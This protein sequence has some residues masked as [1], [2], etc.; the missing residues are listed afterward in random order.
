[1]QRVHKLALILTTTGALVSGALAQ[2]VFQPG[3]P[4]FAAIDADG[5]GS[6]SSTEYEQFH[7]QRMTQRAAQGYGMRRGGNAPAFA[8][9]DRDGDGTV[10]ES[11]LYQLR[12]DRQAARR[13][14]APCPRGM[15]PAF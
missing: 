4:S 10:T 15:P 12:A 6:I 3:P 14:G 8:A 7:T 1:M 11:E 9:A 5:N 2:G 13:G